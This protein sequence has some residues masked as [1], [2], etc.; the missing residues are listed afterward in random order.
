MKNVKR[1]LLCLL[2]VCLLCTTLTGCQALDE[3]RA[4][5]GFWIKPGESFRVGEVTYQRLPE[6]EALE[7]LTVPYDHDAASI[8]VTESDV[9]VLLSALMGTEFYPSTDRRLMV[10]AYSD[11]GDY[12]AHFSET[13]LGY[14]CR[15]ELYAELVQ[16]LQK[17]FEPVGLCCTYIRWDAE[18]GEQVEETYR[19]TA[20][21][22]AAIR[23]LLAQERSYV[24]QMMYTSYDYSLTLNECSE[25]MLLQKP[26][27]FLCCMGEEYFLNGTDDDGEWIINVSAEYLSVAQSLMAPEIAAYESYEDEWEDWEYDEDYEI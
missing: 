4:S 27:V 1:I 19:L 23:A 7:Y 15:S 21:Q 14:Y 9:P 18:T 5:Q 17:G 11:Y 20:P 2:V 26:L 6:S 16:Q 13:S 3:A 8:Y 12:E 22:T 10:A 24:P 25:D